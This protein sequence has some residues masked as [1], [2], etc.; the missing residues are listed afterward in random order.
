MNY[1]SIA[2]LNELISRRLHLLPADVRLV[3]GV[4]RSGL[5]AANLI[6]LHRNLPLTDVDGL[7]ANRLLRGG[8]RCSAQ[9]VADVLASGGKVLVVDDSVC[10]GAAMAGVR[11]RL[12]PFSNA[13]DLLFAAVFAT[14]DSRDRVDLHLEVVPTPRVFEWNALHCGGLTRWC[15]DIDG[16][17]CA[18][19]TEAENDDGERYE[20]FLRNAAPRLTPAREI[21]WLVTGRLAKYRSQTQE[22]L[23]RHGIRYRELVMLDL[24]DRASR[25]AAGGAAG[26][27]ARVYRETGAELFIESEE[28]QAWH[29]AR[30]SGREV[31]CVGSGRLIRPGQIPAA[32]TALR[33]WIGRCHWG[34]R[35]AAARLLRPYID[36]PSYTTRRAA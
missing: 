15:V 26:F 33:A 4:P 32:R 30:F 6:A 8:E 22:W 21:G 20:E 14:P 10:T 36:T 9:T 12:A 5:L 1:R 19:P 7:L 27:K 25:L 2:D 35:R 11:Q 29:I 24:P 17:L 34:T 18:D 13:A 28:A 23:A 31:Y 3:V 16:V